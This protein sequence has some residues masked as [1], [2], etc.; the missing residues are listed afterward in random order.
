[1]CCREVVLSLMC[2]DVLGGRVRANVPLLC[3]LCRMSD[4]LYREK[5]C[6]NI[7]CIQI[8]TL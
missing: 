6:K 8:V 7:N 2:G 1:M 4:F 5:I 3:S